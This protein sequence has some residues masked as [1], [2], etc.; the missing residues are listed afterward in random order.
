M[1]HLMK[2]SP[3]MLV[4][5]DLILDHYVLGA[6][7]RISP[8]A[9]VPVVEVR[10]ERF[11]LGGSGNV[12]NNLLSLGARVFPVSAV[13]NDVAGRKLQ[14]MLCE[15]GIV[16][17]GIEVDD[18]KQTSRKTR[19]VVAHQQM[20]RLDQETTAA[21][22]ATAESGLLRAIDNY[23]ERFDA[24]VVSDYNKG[25]V[26]PSLCQAVIRIARQR[27]IPVL[28]DPK[29][30][31][32]SKYRGA[33]VLTPNKNEACGLTGIALREMRGVGDIG[34][35]LRKELDLGYAVITLSEQGM[36]VCGDEMTHIRSTAREVYDV[37]G[38]GDT[39]LAVM[40]FALACGISITEAAGL[41]NA[42]AGVVVGKSGA[43]TVTWD[44]IEQQRQTAPPMLGRLQDAA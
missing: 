11:S 3:T 17:D 13:G 34:Q 22:S 10:G 25:V 41:A 6:S 19:V 27:S 30:T 24:V 7:H 9:P 33:T 31:D 23:H 4:L 16:C 44:E 29:G 21:V 2:K 28:V 18:Q 20:I 5:G 8:E 32:G 38:A 14:Q 12:V 15:L 39:V 35:R 42:A 1:Q 37:S 26:T 40:S 36:V 43:A